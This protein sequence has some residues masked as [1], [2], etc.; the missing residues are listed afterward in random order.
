MKRKLIGFGALIGFVFLILDTKT[1]CS[2]ATEAVE[3]CLVTVV[4]ALFPFMVLSRILCGFM[5]GKNVP[6]LQ[7]LGRLC[8]IPIGYEFLLVLGLIGGYPVGAQAATDAYKSGCLSKAAYHRLLGFCN[9]AGPA[10]IFGLVAAQFQNPVFS[11]Y[12]WGIHILSAL[13]VGFLIPKACENEHK[14]A[15][16]ASVS[17]PSALNASVQSMA[18]VCG[19][20]ILFRV[21][22]AL[23][24]K[25]LLSHLSQDLHVIVCGFIELTNGCVNLSSISS[26][27]HRFI[28]ACSM[29]N[30]GGLCVGMQTASV[31]DFCGTGMYFPGKLLQTLI[32]LVLSLC[33]GSLL[34]AKIF[35]VK[36]LILCLC[37]IL[38]LALLLFLTKKWW[39]F[40][41][42][43]YII[44]KTIKGED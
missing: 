6:V 2:A 8:G 21:V 34:F 41:Q 44:K 37:S 36:N 22:I 33:A 40:R 18:R 1:A 30:F 7:P 42:E 13:C 14:E 11:W 20:V 31:C 24:E 43:A 26:E 12:I 25:Y 4:P 38:I 32:G 19:W 29:L 16:P 15:I 39:Q 10:F 17:F 3:L 9:N 35:P 5:I 27:G 28:V 23:L